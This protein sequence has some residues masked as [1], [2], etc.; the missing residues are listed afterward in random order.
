MMNP[1]H[2]MAGA[3]VGEIPYFKF[4]YR[5]RKVISGRSFGRPVAVIVAR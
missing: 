5:I 2:A 4:R 3:I 1:Y